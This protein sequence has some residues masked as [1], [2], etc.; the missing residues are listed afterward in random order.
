M[1]E[2]ALSVF[3]RYDLEIKQT[4][5][6]RGSYGCITPDEKYILQE[7]ENSEE[8]L[9]T[10]STLQQYLNENGMLTEQLVPDKDGLYFVVSED[11]YGYILKKFYDLEECNIKNETHVKRATKSLALFHKYCANTE[12]ILKDTKGFHPGKNMLKAFRKHNKEIINIRNYITKRKNK[13]FFERYLQTIIDE[14]H[15]QAQEAYQNLQ[16]IS[17]A[18]MYENALKN[19]E[20]CFGNFNH[21]SIGFYK[22]QSVF[23]NMCRI[24][25]APGIHDLY[26]F[27]RKVLEKN[28]WNISLGH[29]V[30]KQYDN[31]VSLNDSD[32]IIIRTFLEYPEK[33]WKIINYYY[34]SNKA[35]YSEKNEEKLKSF[36][37]QEQ[38][39]WKFI[40]SL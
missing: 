35:W 11:G 27:L 38:K 20:L 26:D 12:E 6:L 37:N 40:Q 29:I 19:K 13:N 7:Y 9:V 25:Y 1:N 24:H 33:F 28:D 4:F 36:Q 15:G 3:D 5:K 14:Y 30:L 17:Y 32:Y 18:E 23:L 34:N 31:I 22:N 10:L 39:R 21:H 2:K 16:S 8:K